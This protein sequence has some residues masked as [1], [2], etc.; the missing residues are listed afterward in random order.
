[1]NQ[2]EYDLIVEDDPV[3][4]KKL[5]FIKLYFNRHYCLQIRINEE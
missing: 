2:C 4:I 3:Y 1:M 5:Y